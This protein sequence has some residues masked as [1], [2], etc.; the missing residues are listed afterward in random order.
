MAGRFRNSTGVVKLTSL[1]GTPAAPPSV[2][3]VRFN[4]QMGL[5]HTPGVP[6][7]IAHLPFDI[8]RSLPPLQILT[9]DKL[10]AMLAHPARAAGRRIS[11]M[12]SINTGDVATLVIN[13]GISDDT[14]VT[15]LQGQAASLLATSADLY[16]QAEQ[17]WNKLLD[18]IK[19]GAIAGAAVGTT[20]GVIDIALMQYGLTFL[21]N[22]LYDLVMEIVQ[23][24]VQA[25][26]IEEVTSITT[27]AAAG[28]TFGYLGAVIGAIIGACIALGDLITGGQ[29]VQITDGGTYSCKDYVQTNLA[30]ARDWLTSNQ[31]KLL[32]L[33]PLRFS[34][35]AHLFLA[36]PW[37]LYKNQKQ[38]GI[39]QPPPP[40]PG[41]GDP[42]DMV[43]ETTPGAY[44][45][46]NRAQ[47]MAAIAQVNTTPQHLDQYA[48]I[49]HP[50][51]GQAR[52]YGDVLSKE[53]TVEATN[54]YGSP[55][56][57]LGVY[58]NPDPAQYK[59]IVTTL[60]G[61]S[62]ELLWAPG[63]TGT[64]TSPSGAVGTAYLYTACP[65]L[66]TND[67]TYKGTYKDGQGKIS[68]QT[69][70]CPGIYFLQVLY[71][72]LTTQ[73]CELIF[74]HCTKAYGV[75]PVL[76]PTDSSGAA[77]LP[78]HPDPPPAPPDP[79]AGWPK[80]W[81]SFGPSVT[82]ISH[83][84]SSGLGGSWGMGS[85]FLGPGLG[86]ALGAMAKAG[87]LPPPIPAV[88][89]SLPNWQPPPLTPAQ[90]IGLAGAATALNAGWATPADAAKAA[91][92]AQAVLTRI[93]ELAAGGHPVAVYNAKIL[94][95]VHRLSIVASYVSK[96]LGTEAGKQIAMAGNFAGLAKGTGKYD[97]NLPLVIEKTVDA[98]LA[99]P[100]ST[101]ADLDLFG[102]ALIQAK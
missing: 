68:G 100:T 76:L 90:A 18:G 14:L 22:L 29:H 99:D 43:Y 10:E 50:L 78:P 25:M 69:D 9:Q 6:I 85:P 33:T 80:T 13:G 31:D 96:Y 35:Q 36:N 30:S 57:G 28:S 83:L 77:P 26:V 74:D 67:N 44:E 59:P 52:F 72:S 48:S 71:P 63:T 4:P 56:H 49:P 24:I 60:Q 53:G 11:T 102:Q 19:S 97:P 8:H 23:A 2:A 1:A 58:P 46:L 51:P 87:T 91:A 65:N 82:D 45:L 81:T 75:V 66:A 17:A 39:T 38:L 15:A 42:L 54:K 20:I 47:F 5:V 3:P 61:N 34:K 37:W 94:D 86:A 101:T 12:A 73:Q 93:H 21:A 70:L 16:N 95:A 88:A 92:D 55:V 41:T 7:K 79:T 98:I 64:D 89:V 32:F 40:D 27:A 84:F 62:I